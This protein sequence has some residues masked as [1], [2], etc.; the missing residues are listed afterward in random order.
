MTAYI[1]RRLLLLPVLL[2]G[3]TVIIFA[4]L[5]FLSPIERSALYVRDIP[6]NDAAVA[7]IIKRYG[8]DEP[9]A[10]AVLALAGG[11]GRPNHRRTHRWCVTRRPGLFAGSARSR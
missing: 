7:G 5:Q 6:K 9:S 3:V 1:I 8:L 10:G 2:A 11:H 4:M